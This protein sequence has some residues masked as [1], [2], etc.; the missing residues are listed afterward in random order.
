V[1]GRRPQ[2][3][4]E[5]TTSNVGDR[6]WGIIP[7]TNLDQDIDPAARDRPAR[8][9]K[10]LHGP[11]GLAAY[12]EHE[13][14]FHEHALRTWAKPSA[15]PDTVRLEK[16]EKPPPLGD[17][18]LPGLHQLFRAKGVD[19]VRELSDCLEPC[20]LEEVWS[21]APNPMAVGE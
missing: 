16:E 21:A 6:S 2:S 18:S 8:T 1:E 19:D 12:L 9:S 13:Q 5:D 14:E 20:G 7:L 10:T 3:T 4:D 17:E 11:K 15:T